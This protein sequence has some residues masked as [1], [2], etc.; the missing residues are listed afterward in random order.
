MKEDEDWLGVLLR[1]WI[2]AMP[3]VRSRKLRSDMSG[4]SNMP[5]FMFERRLGYPRRQEGGHS[6]M[7]LGPVYIQK[8]KAL[9]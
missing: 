4:G 2:R 5:G 7:L 3:D 6:M 9:L 1:G 8:G